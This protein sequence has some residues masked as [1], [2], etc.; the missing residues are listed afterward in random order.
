MS[1]VI[2]D[3]KKVIAHKGVAVEEMIM[4]EMDAKG[5]VDRSFRRMVALRDRATAVCQAKGLETEL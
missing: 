5:E 3:I 2:G 1:E 4:E